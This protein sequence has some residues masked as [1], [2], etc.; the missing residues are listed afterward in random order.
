MTTVLSVAGSTPDV[1]GASYLAPTAVIAG[2]VSLASGVSIWFGSV[3]RAELAPITIGRDSNVQDNCVVHTDL[4]FPA[5]IGD[6]VTVGHRVVL[7]GCT[8]E[9]G[10]LIGMGAVVMNGATIGAGSIV[11][12]GAVVTEGTQVPPG[13]ITVGAPARVLDKPAPQGP[14]PNV[15]G[16][17]ALADAY[18]ETASPAGPA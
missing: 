18:R 9:D 3:L 10:V 16:Y 12:A 13:S 8:V 7:H 5:T 15:A 11:G 14:F 17:L 6:E 1:A 2:D 4:G